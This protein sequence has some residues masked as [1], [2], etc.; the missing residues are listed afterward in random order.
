MQKILITQEEKDAVINELLEQVE[1][2]KTTA[3]LES[4]KVSKDKTKFKDILKPEIYISAGNLEKMY[5]LVNASST[6]CQWH[7]FVSRSQ[8][9]IN[10]FFISDIVVFPQINTGASTDTDE[11]EYTEWLMQ[12][13][14]TDDPVRNIE[15]LRFHGHSHVNMA[16][17]SSSIDD[18]FQRE[19]LANLKEDD[20]YIF[21]VLNK[22]RE[23]CILVYDYLQNILFDTKDSKIILVDE[24]NTIINDWA[25]EELKKNS[26]SKTYPRPAVNYYG[27]PYASYFY[28]DDDYTDWY[29]EGYYD[30][31]AKSQTQTK[32][33]KK[34]F[35]RKR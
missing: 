4:I 24:Q 9:H 1:K 29:G 30:P 5:A 21:F 14:E 26:K 20:Y 13:I 10:R 6:E 8:T 33:T 31:Y 11:N 15:H 7:G 3:E 19:L 27:H 32:K 25:K 17:Y 34:K 2:A 12:F 23:I 35:K 18:T 16:V 22:K 28:E